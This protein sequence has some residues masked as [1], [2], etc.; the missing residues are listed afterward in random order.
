ME[1]KYRYETTECKISCNSTYKL[2]LEQA[3]FCSHCNLDAA[4]SG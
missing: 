3:A 4:E 2:H 1:R